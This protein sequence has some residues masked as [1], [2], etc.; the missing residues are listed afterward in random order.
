MIHFSVE[1]D[2]EVRGQQI[3]DTPVPYI[4][5]LFHRDISEMKFAYLTRSADLTSVSPRGVS[6]KQS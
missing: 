1:Q 5:D 3:I 4:S 6:R 2:A